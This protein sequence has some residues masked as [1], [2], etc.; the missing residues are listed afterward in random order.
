MKFDKFCCG[1]SL[2]KHFYEGFGM[3]RLFIAAFLPALAMVSPAMAQ[4]IKAGSR[5]T[6][7]SDWH[8]QNG[9]PY[10]PNIV[11]CNSDSGLCLLDTNTSSSNNPRTLTGQGLQVVFKQFG[12]VYLFR[13]NGQGTFH[14]LSDKQTGKFTWSQ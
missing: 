14:D 2:E 11:S 4:D 1:D 10:R 13:V 5:V 7:T 8:D 6:I 12:V 9:G 3:L